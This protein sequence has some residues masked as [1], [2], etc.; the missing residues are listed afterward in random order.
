[1]FICTFVLGGFW[2]EG[3]SS[4]WYSIFVGSRSPL[5]LIHLFQFFYPK[6]SSWWECKVHCSLLFFAICVSL[7][8]LHEREMINLLWPSEQ[9]DIRQLPRDLCFPRPSSTGPPHRVQV[10][11]SRSKWRV[12]E[13]ELW[14]K[15]GMSDPL[16]E[17]AKI[18]VFESLLICVWQWLQTENAVHDTRE[19]LTIKINY[20][21]RG[22]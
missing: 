4:L 1:M 19:I 7:Y 15:K 17:N 5:F 10:T 2:W 13:C 14:E 12:V 3:K 22:S 18:F 21:W 16:V 6:V 11:S 8:S 20:R 9:I